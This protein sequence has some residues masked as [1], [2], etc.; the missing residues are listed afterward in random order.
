MTIVLNFN[1][2]KCDFGKLKL[3]SVLRKFVVLAKLIV[4]LRK[5]LKIVK[6]S[7]RLS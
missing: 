2:L 1:L 4:I 3:H 5:K 7:A 6:L